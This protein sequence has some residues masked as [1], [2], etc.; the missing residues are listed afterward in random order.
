[1]FFLTRVPFFSEFPLSSFC[2]VVGPLTY[3]KITHLRLD[4]NNLTRADLPQEMYNCLRVAAE[5]SLEW[6]ALESAVPFYGP[7]LQ[8]L[9]HDSSL[10]LGYVLKKS[11][12][13]YY[14]FCL[15]TF[16]MHLATLRKCVHIFTKGCYLESTRMTRCGAK[17]AFMWLVKLREN[18][19]P[20]RNPCSSM[21]YVPS[22]TRRM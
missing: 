2:K 14:P 15:L 3:S 11:Q 18:T 17:Y 22:G 20:D 6:D 10:N 1:M 9:H 13:A 7:L 12:S 4:G 16:S 21:Q 8:E 19:Q 5:I